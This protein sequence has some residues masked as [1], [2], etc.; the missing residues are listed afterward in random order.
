MS[1]RYSEL[2]A[3][4]P[5]R[6][7]VRLVRMT[8]H[9]C[10]VFRKDV[11]SSKSASLAHRESPADGRAISMIEREANHG[12]T[13]YLGNSAVAIVRPVSSALTFPLLET[14]TPSRVD[15]ERPS[16]NPVVESPG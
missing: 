8:I 1:S 7:A 16:P 13:V 3:T 14:D 12:A 2:D 10:F 6:T 11:F 5:S 9:R 15:N 4:S